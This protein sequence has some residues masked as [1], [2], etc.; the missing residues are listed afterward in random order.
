M[1]FSIAMVHDFDK[2][3]FAGKFDDFCKKIDNH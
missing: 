1:P 3:N 2:E